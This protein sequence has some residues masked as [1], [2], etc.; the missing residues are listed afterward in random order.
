MLG[1]LGLSAACAGDEPTPTATATTVAPVGEAPAVTE[2]VVAEVTATVE[3]PAYD[4]TLIGKFGGELRAA[5]KAD[6]ITADTILGGSASQQIYHGQ[7]YSSLIRLD[8]YDKSNINNIIPDLATSWEVEDGG[9]TFVFHLRDD[10][11]WHGTTE[12]VDCQDVLTSWAHSLKAGPFRTDFGALLDT[13]EC[14]DERTPVFKLTAASA[15][16]LP[17][18]AQGGATGAIMKHEVLVAKGIGNTAIMVPSKTIGSGPFT[19]VS[20]DKADGWRAERSDN[21]YLFDKAGNRLPY[22]DSYV[23]YPIPDDSVWLTAFKGGQLD[24]IPG[25]TLETRLANEM[26]KAL[27]DTIVITTDAADWHTNLGK[28]KFK[29][30]EDYRVR[31]AIHLAYDRHANA[32]IIDPNPRF[33]RVLGISDPNI[34]GIPQAELWQMPGFRVDKTADIAEAN[35]L[36]D[37]AGYPRDKTGLRFTI[38]DVHTEPVQTYIDRTTLYMTDLLPLGIAWKFNQPLDRAESNARALSCNYEIR[39]FRGGRGFDPDQTLSFMIILENTQYWNCG[40]RTPQYIQD[41]Y[42]D[43]S[44]TLDPLARA[45]KVKALELAYFEDKEI[46]YHK[47]TEHWLYYIAGW[48]GYVKGPGFDGTPWFTRFD[49]QRWMEVWVDRK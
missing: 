30:F 33:A 29:P 10:A 11:F 49:H 8:P 36:L 42:T 14:R 38:N 20:A 18:M 37:E 44:I 27:P 6:W 34:G 23:S 21:Y 31:K 25:V 15:K 41:A 40:Y 45:Q 22:L 35:R 26:Q 46:G 12:V 19:F 16:V 17:I 2:T 1:V 13:T 4:V 43:Q 39:D 32:P 24:Y 48:R 9:K 7:H 5:V 47:I 28:K 3:A